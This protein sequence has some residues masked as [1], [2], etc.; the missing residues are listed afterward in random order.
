VSSLLDASPFLRD[1]ASASTLDAA[2]TSASTATSAATSATSAATNA[3]TS[4]EA[5][6]ASAAASASGAWLL[7]SFVGSIRPKNRGYSFGVRQKIFQLY[8]STPGFLLRD[9]R[10]ESIQVRG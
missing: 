1:D 9:L 8:N 10:G 6:S 5:S 3:V 4:L 2:A 7:L